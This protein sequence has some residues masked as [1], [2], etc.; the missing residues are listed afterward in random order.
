MIL[1]QVLLEGAFLVLGSLANNQPVLGQAQDKSKSVYYQR[2]GIKEV[3]ILWESMSAA[4]II[5]LINACNPWNKGAI[6]L[7]NNNEVKLLDAE[8]STL[9]QQTL[10]AG[11][12]L[13]AHEHLEVV[14]LNGQ[15]LQVNI[16]NI[17]GIFI[18]ARFA[19][20]FG[21]AKGQRFS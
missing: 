16:L 1:S 10:P 13:N 4:E 11:T 15:V 20:K 5:N 19:A 18:P 6:S 21:F 8:L 7:Y 14:C 2:P 9:P 3:S 17:N 12:I